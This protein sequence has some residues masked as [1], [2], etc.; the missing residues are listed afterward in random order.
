[1]PRSLLLRC[2]PLLTALVVAAP[3]RAAVFPGEV[4]DG[5]SADIVSAGDL[6]LA[7]DGSGALAY[8]KRVDGVPH[9]FASRLVDGAWSAPERLDPAL[10]GPAG[11]PVVTASDGGRAVVAFTSAG[12]LQAVL[13]PGAAAAFQAPQPIADGASNPSLDMSLNGVAYL[14]FT[15]PGASAADVRVARLARGGTAFAVLPDVLDI[16]PAQDAGVGEDG[17]SMAVSADGTA[18]V[19]WGEAGH[20]YARR[21]FGA[22]ISTAPQQVDVPVL[23]GHAGGPADLSRIDIEDDSSYAWVVARQRFD[24]GRAHVIARRLVG[25]AF[26]PPVQVDGFGYPGGADASELAVAMNGRGEGLAAASGGGGVNAAALHDDRFFPTA[27]LGA[28]AA[29]SHLAVAMAESNDGYASWLPGDGTVLLRSYALD[30]AKRTVPPPVAATNLARP[31]FGPALAALGGGLAVNRVG[32]ASVSFVQEAADGRRLLVGAFDRPP[33]VF[34]GRTSEKFRQLTRPPLAWGVSFDL[35]GRIT[36]RVELDGAAVGETLGT[37]FSLAAPLADGV[38][39]W[40]VVATDRR[41]QTAATAPRALRVDT[42]PPVVRVRV[43]GRRLAGRLVTAGLTAADGSFGAPAGSGVVR[44]RIDWGDR[45]APAR[46]RTATHRYA[47]R[48]RYT[49]RVSATDAAGNATV[50]TTALTV[51]KKR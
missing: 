34:R 3:A 49:V 41:G 45:T 7:R 14:S 16:A 25:S 38:H 18:V 29:L 37:T 8:L 21:V 39:T 46:R 19:S 42:R 23:D 26:D 36:Y 27:P 22:R 12:Q 20:V 44:T 43:T 17:S 40:R 10:G 5:P 35:V 30:A 32:D 6:D 33:T 31:E 2:L 13:R 47:K 28:G 24:D 51:K 11:E 4:V 50:R 15:A 1:M 9:V 48:G